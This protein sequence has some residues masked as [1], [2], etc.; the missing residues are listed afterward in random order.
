MDRITRFSLRNAAA[1]VLVALLVTAG[2]LW[3]AGQLKKETMPDID[4]PVVAVVVPYPG[5]APDDVYADI[6]DPLEKALGGVAG[7]KQVSAQSGDSVSMVVLQFSYSQDMD[8]AEADVNKV[9]QTVTLPA[10]AITPKVSRISFGSAPILKLA[11]IGEGGSGAALRTDVRDRVIPALQGVEGVGEAHL[12]ADSPANIRIVFDSESLKDEGLTAESVIQQL[13]AANLSFPVGAVDLGSSTEPIR[14]GGTIGSVEDLEN[15]KIAVYPNQSEIMADAFAQIGDGMAGLGQAVGG[16]AQ[17]MGQGFSALGQGMGTLGQATGEI[18]MQAGLIN[19]MQQLQ[20][21]V[22]TLK[23]DTLPGLKAA[24]SSMATD[25][26]EYAALQGQIT[27]IETQAIPGMQAA[28]DGMQAQVTA[29]QQKLMAQAGSS[30]GS[31]SMSSGGSGASMKM[32]SGGSSSSPAVE[33]GMVNLSDVAE[34]TYG[35]ADGSVGSRADGRP[36]AL[37]DIVKTQDA[38][39]VDVSTQVA[40]E[41]KKLA[42]ELPAGTRVETVYDASVGINA[43]VSGMMREGL[44]GALFAVIVILIFLRNW[45]A[46]IIAAVSIPLSVLIAMVFLRFSGVT[47]NVMTLGGLTVAIG[48]VVD[49]S[50]VVIENIFRHMQ[51]GEER[52]AE[53]VRLATSEVSAAIT[54]STLTTVA[55]F[56]PLGLVTGVIGKIFQPFAITV[57]MSLLASLLVAITVVPLMAKWF[58]LKAKLPR[59]RRSEPKPM[60]MYRRTLNWSLTHRWTVVAAA[61][62]LLLGSLSL[63]PL[64]GTGFVPE[65][66]EKYLQID[67]TYP[68][69]TKAT[70]VNKAVLGIEEAV[71][72]EKE[73]ELY[74]STVG[75]SNSAVSM[76]TSLGGSNKALTFVK[77]DS[78]ANSDAVVKR[79]KAKTSRFEAGGTQI[80][81]Q[82]V[83]SSGTSSQLDIVITGDKMADIRKASAQIEG[84][85][86]GFPGL[87]NVSSNLGVSR[88][89]LV[90]SV[91]EHKAAKYGMNAAM[92]AGT[93]RGYVADQKAGTIKIDGKVTDVV[94]AFALNNVNKATEMSGLKLSTP[95]GK[96]IR[97]DKIAKV[98]E[99][100]SPVAVLTRDGVQYASVSGRITERDS[101]SVIKAVNAKLAALKLPA[102]V[103]TETSGAAEQMNESFSQLGVAMLIAVGAV[104][105]VMIIA[106]GEAIAPLAIMMSLP[107]AVV[108]GLIGLLISGLPLDIPAMIGSLMLIGIVVTN[109]IVLV[110]RVQ[111]K[112]RAGMSRHDALLEAGSTRMRPILMTAV[113]TIMALVPLAS[114]F[115]EGALISQSLAVIVI[116]GLTT[117]TML[118]LIVVP[119]AYDLLESAKERLIGRPIAES[120]LAPEAA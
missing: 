118:T 87:E 27:G 55:V 100:D 120:E 90:V 22:Y 65:A 81:Y 113:A 33:I 34:I 71:S 23:Y 6:T 44:L 35:P 69:G 42:S 37:V 31:S 88:K 62:A 4:I 51:R 13:Q 57:A 77:L 80:A 114:G 108:G 78:T 1:I 83:N 11:I 20:A 53:L 12:A 26:P 64:I 112:R 50:I 91:D 89:Q 94:Y 76:S 7:V 54:S 30:S 60:A 70:E 111:Q 59:E 67:V 21:E 92:V 49:D 28:I 68:E 74:Q 79:L 39:T 24:A 14:V 10:N 3:S 107:L 36:A 104:Y 8:A 16:L 9:L 63:M 84:V 95:L 43:S 98:K 99:A 101:G 58:L 18:G 66:K 105:L 5:A 17:G 38:N 61:L 109:A 86:N 15:F 52:N 19:G 93:V 96:S 116:G 46:T 102:G 110:D 73:V 41:M 29:S 82:M 97:L 2:G 103:K 106:F 75:D 40:A 72:Q 45:R 32:P 48:R 115:A 25:T 56:L 47:L 117:S 119:V 85:M